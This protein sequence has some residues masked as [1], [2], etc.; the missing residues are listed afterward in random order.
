METKSETLASLEY[1][2]AIRAMRRIAVVGLS[3]GPWRTSYG[4]SRAM[5]E[6]GY[7]I[8]PVNPNETEVLGQR[9]YANLSNLPEP[10]EVVNVFRRPEY[11]SDIVDEAIAVGAKAIW[12]QIGVVDYEAARRAREAGII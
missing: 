6:A 11:I 4:I 8:T 12:L 9:A 1:I 2:A 5:Q 3:S 10:P 7:D